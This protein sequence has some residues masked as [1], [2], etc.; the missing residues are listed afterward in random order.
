VGPEL[1]FAWREAL[2]ALDHVEAQLRVPGE[3]AGAVAAVLT[4]MRRHPSD[5]QG[6]YREGDALPVEAALLFACRTGCAT[7]G[8]GPRWPPPSKG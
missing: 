8:A 3:R 7:T 6:H 1:T 2:V 4:E 5:W